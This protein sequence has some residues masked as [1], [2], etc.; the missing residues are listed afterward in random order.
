[1]QSSGWLVTFLNVWV[2][3]LPSS[4]AD[5]KEKLTNKVEG[6]YCAPSLHTDLIIPASVCLAHTQSTFSSVL[7][8]CSLALIWLFQLSGHFEKRAQNKS[9][10]FRISHFQLDFFQIPTTLSEFHFNFAIIE[11]IH[12]HFKYFNVWK[13]LSVRVFITLV[14]HKTQVPT[15]PLFITFS[16]LSHTQMPVL[17]LWCIKKEGAAV[18]NEPEH[19][20]DLI[21]KFY[22]IKPL[23]W[24]D[25]ML[26]RSFTYAQMIKNTMG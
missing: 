10:V 12:F 18:K 23:A 22:L 14:R 7:M 19:L 9:S 1:M 6:K 24:S 13:W 3:F 17:N 11:E 16:S 4:H 26:S 5:M 2:L 8:S 20:A 15:E 25:G 21:H